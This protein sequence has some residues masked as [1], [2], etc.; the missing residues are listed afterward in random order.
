MTWV[1]RPNQ[2]SLRYLSELGVACQ[3]PGPE[4]EQSWS[5]CQGTESRQGHQDPCKAAPERT[6]LQKYGANQAA[7][8]TVNL[9]NQT[10]KRFEET[11]LCSLSAVWVQ[12]TM[13]YIIS[14][15]MLNIGERRTV[16]VWDVTHSTKSW[17]CLETYEQAMPVVV[18]SF[19]G[20]PTAKLC[21]TDKYFSSIH[22]VI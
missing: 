10:E 5:H 8:S 6:P 15:A 17:S 11:Q 14:A 21:P 16:I 9:A 18:S 1:P 3:R 20:L 13:I 22:P 12:V 19:E 4:R 7:R 2:A